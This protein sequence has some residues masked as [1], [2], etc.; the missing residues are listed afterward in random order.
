M[1]IFLISHRNL[2]CEPSSELSRHNLN[3]LIETVQM[4][5]NSI[6]LYAE[7][8][9]IIPNYHQILP[10]VKSSGGCHM[11]FLIPYLYGYKTGVLSL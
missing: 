6:C 10:L 5:A 2:C 9:K 1:I 4:S 7:L 11:F 3:R 8:T